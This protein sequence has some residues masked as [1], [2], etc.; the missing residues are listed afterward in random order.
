MKINI[1]NEKD[2]IIGTKERDFLDDDKDIYRV[3]ALWIINSEGKSLMAQRVF[4]KKHD[5]GKWGPAVAGTNDEGETY[6]SNIIK[7][8]EEELGLEN[9]K[10]EFLF[11]EFVN[12]K[13]KHFTQWYFLKLDKSLDS[14]KV[15]KNEVEKIEWLSF[16]EILELVKE[17]KTVTLNDELLNLVEKFR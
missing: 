15:D 16:D 6:E 12:G 4:S 2:E 11:K 13:Y 14:F 17:N 3:S 9:I 8:A 5:S 7:E 10:P 1:V